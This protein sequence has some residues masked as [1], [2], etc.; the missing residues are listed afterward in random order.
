MAVE[1]LGCTWAAISTTTANVY[2]EP[3]SVMQKAELV[4]DYL[5]IGSKKMLLP[6]TVPE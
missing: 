4:I 5:E 6:C 2:H 1:G 3:S